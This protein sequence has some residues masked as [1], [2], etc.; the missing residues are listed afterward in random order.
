MTYPDNIR[1]AFHTAALGLMAWQD[2]PAELSPSEYR[3]LE[4]IGSVYRPFDPQGEVEPYNLDRDEE[5]CWRGE[6]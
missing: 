1:A 4:A 2:P 6:R 5:E 3:R